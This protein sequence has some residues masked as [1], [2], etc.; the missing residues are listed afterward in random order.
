MQPKATVAQQTSFLMPTPTE[1]CG[2]GQPLTPK[3]KKRA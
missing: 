1:Q 3:E 2:Q